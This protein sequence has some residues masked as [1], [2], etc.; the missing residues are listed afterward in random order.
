MPT[1]L[2]A[3]HVA[4]RYGGVIALADGSLEVR[5]GEVVALVGA[6]GSGK[7][8]LSKILTGVVAPDQGALALD[9]AA[10]SFGNPHAARARGVT[11]VYQE[12]SLLPDMTVA[13]NIWLTHE[14]RR[15][16]LFVDQG[17]VARQTERLLRLFDGA[18]SPALTA[19]VPVRELPPDE[20][21]IVE[22]LKALSQEPRV[23]ILDEA[24]ASLDSRQVARL[25]D[26]VGGW[27]QAG[28]GVVFV[29]HR[30]DEIFRLADRIVVLR[31]GQTVGELPRGGA[32]EQDVV[33][34]MT[35]QAGAEDARGAGVGA[36]AGTGARAGVAEAAGE[37]AG[38][39]I[40]GLMG[41][42]AGSR[43]G[44]RRLE[45]AELTTRAVHGVS[46]VLDDGELLG[47]GGL[48]GQG[49]EDILLALF[50]ALPHGGSIRM[51][52]QAAAY[53]H[54]QEAMAAGV[55]YVPGERN[56]QGLLGIRS[57]LENLQL[58]SWSKYGLP[59]RMGEARRDGERVARDLR[60]VMGGLDAPV[61]SLSG[62]NAQK[63]VL[64]KWLLRSPQLLLLNDPTKGVDV[65]AKAE[66][67][68]LLDD[69]RRGGAAILF[70]SSDD[71][72]LL[73][74]CDRVLVLHD[75]R[76][77]STLQGETLTRGN[78]VAA[79]VGADGEGT[80]GE[81]G[82][83]VSGGPGGGTGG[84]T[85]GGVSGGTGAGTGAGTGGETGGGTDGG[86][87]D[88]SGRG[89]AGG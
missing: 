62:G 77:R 74:L 55:A 4:K 66:I 86:A 24:T 19:D 22:I 47:L 54:P 83:G 45:V 57:I 16:G 5:A 71:E 44:V 60:I 14:P 68:R 6:N 29:S 2:S 39:A 84:G 31:N 11:A 27:K 64:G 67:Y 53:T 8:T 7:S 21:Q 35:G 32:R 49:Q 15:L 48:R 38:G 51:G 69:L 61:S 73:A 40:G 75:G 52:G 37:R 13:E 88:E 30:M 3:Q 81:A 10:I 1:I 33:A 80:G 42:A 76:I 72:E 70:Y 28:R 34:L 58:P 12:L 36:L 85:G 23:I 46:F 26:L 59:L 50:G 79:S 25:F 17:A 78:L 41:G 87:G 43:A 18:I 82:A 65:G 20:K 63:V 56:A 89:G 9:G